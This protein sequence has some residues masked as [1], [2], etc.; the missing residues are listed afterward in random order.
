MAAALCFAA[1]QNCDYTIALI[2]LNPAQA[3]IVLR[4]ARLQ[5]VLGSNT[6]DEKWVCGELSLKITYLWLRSGKRGIHDEIVIL[7]C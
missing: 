1:L 7:K 5:C 2:F 6:V 4:M 3:G